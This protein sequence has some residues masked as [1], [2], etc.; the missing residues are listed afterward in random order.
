M[1]LNHLLLNLIFICSIFSISQGMEEKNDKEPS[2]IINQEENV[3]LGNRPLEIQAAIDIAFEQNKEADERSWRDNG[4]STYELL[5]I[6]DDLMLEYLASKN[7]EK[8]DIYIID[9][10]CAQGNWGHNALQIL[11]NEACK[12]SGKRFH[13]FSVTGGKECQEMIKQKDHVTLYQLNYFKIENIDEEFLKRG[14]DLKEKV[15]LIVSNWTLRHLVDPFGTLKRMYGLLTPTQGMVL[16]NGFLFKFDNSDEIQAFPEDSYNIFTH[17]NA[18]PLFRNYSAGRD[19][20]QFLLMR[21]NKN[22]LEI[23]LEYT[24][25]VHY[26]GPRYQCASEHVTVF[27]IGSFIKPN[28]DVNDIEGSP[29]LYYD[30][31]DDQRCKNLYDSLN[32]HK[33]FFK[34]R[35]R[36][37]KKD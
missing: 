14:F 4:D 2:T 5:G 20:G 37:K 36:H 19:A 24:E 10:G 31:S 3:V 1:N 8:E 23:P 11:Q 34:S 18:T 7:P 9:V 21:N 26:I 25:N 22:E 17:A 13:I 28:F 32:A 33:L 35:I 16:S 27:K 30:K 12:K 15:D 29:Q 6:D